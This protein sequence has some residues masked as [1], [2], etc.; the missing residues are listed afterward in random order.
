MIVCLSSCFF[1]RLT[2]NPFRAFS[3]QAF[4]KSMLTGQ[5]SSVNTM[6]KIH[7]MKICHGEA[8]YLWKTPGII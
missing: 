8:F 6:G 1:A 5:P 7:S 2:G 4:P 3:V